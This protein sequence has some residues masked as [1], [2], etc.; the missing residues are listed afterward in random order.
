MIKDLTVNG[1]KNYML[2]EAPSLLVDYIYEIEPG[3]YAKGYKNFT[4]TESF[5][6]SH[7]PEDPNVPSAVMIDAMSQILC[8][9]FLT[10]PGNERKQTACLRIDKVEFKRKVIPGDSLDLVA[11][12]KSYRKGIAIGKVSGSVKEQLACKAEFMICIPEIIENL[13]PESRE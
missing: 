3:E 11:D 1:I 12:L 4:Y 8:M 10:V 2:L 9:T 6:K 5:F 7:F 13:K